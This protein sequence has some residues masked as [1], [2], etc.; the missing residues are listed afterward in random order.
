MEKSIPEIVDSMLQ[1]LCENFAAATAELDAERAALEKESSEIQAARSELALLLPAK[2][3]QAE[4][5]A[6]TLLLQGRHEEAQAKRAEQLQAERA[7]DE[8]ET[9]LVAITGRIEQIAAGKQAVALRVY[10]DWFPGLRAVLLGEQTALVDS[11]DKAWEGIQRFAVET[12]AH[13]GAMSIAI[14]STRDDLT[15]RE[16]GPEKPLFDRLMDWFSWGGR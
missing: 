2:A 6:D 4:R 16:L 5:E 12:S 13:R 1:Q 10:D 9:R 7:P 8:M 15:A 14:K 3:R 11:F